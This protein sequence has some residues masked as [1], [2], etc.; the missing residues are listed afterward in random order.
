MTY[1]SLQACSSLATFYSTLPQ[2]L[3]EITAITLLSCLPTVSGFS[4]W[5]SQQ[6]LEV[7]MKWRTELCCLNSFLVRLLGVMSLIENHEH[8]S[9]NLLFNFPRIWPRTCATLEA[10]ERIALLH[11]KDARTQACVFHEQISFIFFYSDCLNS[12][13]SPPVGIISAAPLGWAPYCGT[14]HS[15]LGK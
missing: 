10:W 9:E 15:H 12:R 6:R 5:E 8:G 4:H 11:R 14:D 1:P 3:T 7:E 13:N 2:R